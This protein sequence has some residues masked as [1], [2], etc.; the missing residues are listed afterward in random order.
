MDRITPEC[1][2]ANMRAVRS[3]N[4]KPELLVR[5]AVHRLGYRY[6][7]HRSQLPGSPDLVFA[8]LRMALFVHGC[9]WHSHPNCSKASTPTSNSEFWATKLKR[10]RERDIRAAM[11]LRAMGW[12][13]EVIWECEALDASKLS[14]RLIEVFSELMPL[15][16]PVR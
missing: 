15:P 16:A 14:Q 8:R 13:V 4:T 6:R 5:R 11:E 12:R 3:R 10:N 2:S 9:F 7:L 1:R